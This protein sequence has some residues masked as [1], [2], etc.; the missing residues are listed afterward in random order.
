MVDMATFWLMYPS[1][2][3]Y[4]SYDEIDINDSWPKKFNRRK[5][6]PDNV[7][8]LMPATIHGFNFQEKKW[9]NY[10]S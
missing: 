4:Y 10:I 1:A 8:M 9:G 3:P 5:E 6:V 7:L 2:D